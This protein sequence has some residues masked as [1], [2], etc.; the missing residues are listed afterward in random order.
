MAMDGKGGMSGYSKPKD[1]PNSKRKVKARREARKASGM[2]AQKFYV[3]TRMAEA[4]KSG[5][6]VDRK[7]LRQKFQSGDVARKGFGAPRK[8]TGT[9]ATGGATGGSGGGTTKPKR[10]GRVLAPT[11]KSQF[12]KTKSP[13]RGRVIG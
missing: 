6:K 12:D 8:K 5:K 2:S 1:N 3:K 4:A 11:D 9:K 7:A 10:R 13:R